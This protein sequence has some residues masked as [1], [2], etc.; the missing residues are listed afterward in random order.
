M[1]AEWREDGDVVL[2]GSLHKVHAYPKGR[3]VTTP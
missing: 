2:I 3:R 1:G